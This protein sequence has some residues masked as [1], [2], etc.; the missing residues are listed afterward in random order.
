MGKSSREHISELEEFHIDSLSEL[1]DKNDLPHMLRN[2]FDHMRDRIETRVIPFLK[3]PDFQ[4]LVDIELRENLVRFE[5][6]A[7]KGLEQLRLR[8]MSSLCEFLRAIS[9]KRDASDAGDDP[10]ADVSREMEEKISDTVIGLMRT[11][12]DVILG[13]LVEAALDLRKILFDQVTPAARDEF[14]PDFATS[15]DFRRFY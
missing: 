7:F 10:L 6:R 1:R 3:M 9:L 15:T 4:E 2:M 8:Q 13:E 5:K 12:P 11:P 14:S